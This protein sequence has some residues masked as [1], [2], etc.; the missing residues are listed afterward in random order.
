MGGRYLNAE[1]TKIQAKVDE[2]TDQI[3]NLNKS[4]DELK[5][6]INNGYNLLCELHPIDE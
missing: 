2:Q 3:T 6:R 1:I 4:M 5:E